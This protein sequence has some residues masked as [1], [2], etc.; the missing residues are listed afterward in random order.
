MNVL[1]YPD[2][3]AFLTEHGGRWLEN[4]AE[5]G[6]FLRIKVRAQ[7]RA[8]IC[9][10]VVDGDAPVLT[11]C[12]RP[13]DQI[14]F[15]RAD[16]A[17]LACLAG[18]LHRH[19]IVFPGLFAPSPA[20]RQFAES[21]ARRTGTTFRVVKQMTHYGLSGLDTIRASRGTFRKAQ[22]ADHA[23]LASLTDAFQEEGNTQR[24]FDAGEAVARDLDAGSLYVWEDAGGRVVSM[25]GVYFDRSPRSGYVDGVYTV[26][27]ARTKGYATS[28]VYELSTIVLDA[29]LVPR[30]S[31]DSANAPARKVYEALGY[32][33]ACQMDNMRV[34]PVER[35]DRVRTSV[36]P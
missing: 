21:Y 11:A 2:V 19:D 9:L 20:S 27:E 28:L 33:A 18:Y 31:V 24:P 23:L 6:A 8:L 10:A 15:S 5:D 7:D 32:V 14:L 22:P 16:P 1:R 12:V 34:T 26:P 29:G 35:A 36:A 30:L 17:V 4:E 25:G 3:N 13:E